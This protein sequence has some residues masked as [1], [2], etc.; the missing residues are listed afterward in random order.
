MR[1]IIEAFLTYGF[2]MRALI[3]G[4]LV[5]LC[6]SLLGVSLVLKRYSMIGDGLSHVA[7][8]ALTLSLA[9]NISPLH[10]S[11][12]VVMIAAVLLLRISESNK[13]KGDAA[14]AIITS[15]SLAIGVIS[16]SITKGINIDVFN[17]MFGSILAMSKS[18]VYLSV[19]LSLIVL[20]LYI[21]FH[22]KIFAVTFDENFA[23]ASGINTNLQNTLIALLTA[24]TIVV[25]MRIMGALLISSLIVFPALTSMRV[26]KSFRG[27]I[28]TSAVVSVVCFIA[29]LFVSYGFSTP[30]GAS[31]VASNLVIFLL[32]SLAGLI[33]KK[34]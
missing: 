22:N 13:I 9:L 11:L 10:I 28:I 25:G 30:A 4:V 19:A 2:L 23:K 20:T 15:S 21:V 6:S 12:P 7:F 33:I 24:A 26:C 5:A 29:G 17:F 18:D 16:A 1:T 27:V 14:V 3:A 32:F 31:V 34:V 8:G